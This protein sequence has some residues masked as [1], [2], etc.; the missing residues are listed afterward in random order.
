MIGNN[1]MRKKAM[2]V[3]VIVVVIVVI[4][5]VFVECPDNVKKNSDT[6]STQGE[7]Y[8]DEDMDQT[9][10]TGESNNATT[11]ERKEAKEQLSDEERTSD[12]ASGGTTISS[13]TQSDLNEMEQG[14]VLPE[15][16]WK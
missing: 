6:T 13:Q 9:D 15:H 10:T 3:A 12:D 1:V 7:D 5:F 11:T 16:E 2:I 8:P 4:C 14:I